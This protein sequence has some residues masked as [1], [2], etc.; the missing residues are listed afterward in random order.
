MSRGV[1]A[2]L[3]L[4]CNHLASGHGLVEGGDLR[5][6]PYR[7]G[8]CDCEISQDAPMGALSRAQFEVWERA[9]SDA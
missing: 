6:G 5:D 7:C 8:D 1:Y 4:A 3:C 2:Y 9:R